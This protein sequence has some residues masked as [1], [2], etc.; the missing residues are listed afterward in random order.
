MTQA[1]MRTTITSTSASRTRQPTLVNSY[2]GAEQD[3]YLE[4]KIRLLTITESR[5]MAVRM[6]TRATLLA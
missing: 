5:L 1:A 3:S 4:D 2:A 6:D